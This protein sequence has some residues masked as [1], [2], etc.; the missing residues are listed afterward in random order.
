ME[1]GAGTEPGVLRE[2]RQIV[3]A[4][5][6]CFFLS[7]A[8]GLIYEVLWTR[9]LGLVFGHTVFAITT[10]LSAFMAGLGLGSYLF[11]RIAD[12]HAHPLWLYG[13]LEAGI[14][15]YALLT[16]ILFSKAEDIYIPLYRS[17]ELSFFALNLA[18]F[19]LIFVILLVP[20]TL[21]GGTLP[22][23]SRFFVHEIAALGGQVGRLYAFNTFGAAL[24]TYLAGFHLLPTLGIQLSLLLAAILNIGIAALAIV[25]D[26][27]L[28]RLGSLPP[29]G[30]SPG[31]VPRLSDSAASNYPTDAGTQL[32][33]WL[34]VIGLG[35][36]GAASMMYEVAWT[37]ALA[38]II[39][40][41]TYAF[42]TMLVTFLTGL[43]LGSYLFS[44]V[45]GRLRINPFLFGGLQLGIGLT[46]LAVTP[47][48]DRLPE[49]FLWAFQL[50]QSPGFMKGLQFTISALAMFLPTF[51]MGAT[52]PCV[53]QIASQEIERVGHDVGRI[54]FVNTGGAIAGTVL[55]GF[56]LIPTWGLQT[57]LKLAVSLNLCLALAL[58]ITST[59][60]LRWRR[61][62]ATLVPLV[63]MVVL[64]LSPAWD[65]KAMSSG[66]AIY[67]QGYLALQE[68]LGLRQA[69]D[70]GNQLVYYKDG[71]STTVS[72]HRQGDLLSLRVNGKTDASNGGDMRTQ[73]MLGHLPLSYRPHARRVLVIGMG[74]G[75]TAGAVALHPV[76]QVDLIEIEPAVVEAAGFFA[77]ENRDVLKNPR[78]RVRIADGRNF[79]LASE[80]G[81][82][83][84]ISQPSNPWIRGIGN[85]FSQEFYELA[86]KRLVPK[87]I[88]CQWLEL[89]GL[90][91]EDV[92]MVVKTFRSVFPHTVIWNTIR[93]DLLLIGG[94]EPLTLDNA[95]LHS[96]YDSI[97]GLR[98]DMGR[99]GYPSPLAILAD[100]L[101]DEE[102]TVRFS[103]HALLNTDDLPLLE[104]SAPNSM[105]LELKLI[106][107]NRR[108]LKEFRQ[109]EFP[110][111]VGLPAGILRSPEFRR[112]L[113][114]AFWAKGIPEDAL[115]QFDEALRLEPRHAG[116]LLQRGRI[117]VRLN[118][119][120]K[121]EADFQAALRL[122]PRLVE[123]HDAL[124]QLYL[125]QK[126][127]DLA[128][129]HLRKAA[130]LR[131]K[132]AQHLARL[133]DLYRDSQ[134]FSQAIPLYRA[135]IALDPQNA[136][137]WTG[138][139]MALR[140][141]DR[142][143][144]ALEALHQALSRDPEN[145]FLHYQ[146]GLIHVAA[147]RFNDAATA[148]QA[149][150]LR[151]PAKPDPYIELGR[152]YAQQGEQVKAF[153][154]YR[155][156]LRLDPSNVTAFR[157][158]EELAAALYGGS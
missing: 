65:T 51:L 114:H 82:D 23:L 80:G 66:V 116:T 28:S 103:Q 30:V 60:V 88:V 147:K 142:P 40:S 25:F 4:V 85:L 75:V 58:F 36:S 138:L 59:E 108:L 100:F 110:P 157:A 92:K 2:A 41:S 109:G 43:A 13:L 24:G 29:R 64:F 86:A 52:F 87:G 20:T 35:I 115:I 133:A 143:G 120:L 6:L 61:G 111:I 27:H 153:E 150:A 125:A 130:T 68:K 38:L 48:L 131:P 26:R 146:L 49:V 19:L 76:K 56:L 32:A 113:G 96:K 126:M 57:T 102:A 17:L 112:T 16:P 101:L 154:A 81:Y 128:E 98:E 12:R 39:G 90:F 78:V 94:K 42:S 117:H 129:E 69:M 3:A 107:L 54:Y 67:G 7:G 77:K 10:V 71:I 122:D 97:P 124:A 9:L 14:G 1:P 121:A 91:P 33:V 134:R 148:F 37:R 55:A 106:G 144:E 132:D 62:V 93:G 136:R 45:A 140:G 149:A 155:Q 73:L 11:G 118:A 5:F 21:M 22:V 46:A 44:R 18:Q 47:F 15:V 31:P 141:S 89:Y 119:I 74:S 123:A 152:L 34:A 79:L 127:W 95:I 151:D 50:S 135:A 63:A 53:A 105:H 84:I 156:A 137:L 8:T 158:V 104:F 72:L 145:G 139:G 99:L 83:V 70:S